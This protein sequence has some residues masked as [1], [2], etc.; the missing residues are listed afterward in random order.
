M[1][2]RL[3]ASSCT[4]SALELVLA[5]Q[6]VQ[7]AIRCPL[8][9]AMYALHSHNSLAPQHQ[10]LDSHG[11]MPNQAKAGRMIMSLS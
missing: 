11:F 2:L 5:A 8:Q 1:S 9:S 10:R 7:N 3:F 6:L 4:V